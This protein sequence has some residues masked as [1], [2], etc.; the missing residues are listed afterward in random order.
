MS[1]ALRALFIKVEQLL[2][3]IVMTVYWKT[4]PRVIH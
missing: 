3:E 1:S 4:L 2:Y